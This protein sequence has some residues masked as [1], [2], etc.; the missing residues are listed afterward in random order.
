ME[1]LSHLS[2][3]DSNWQLYQQ[4]ELLPEHLSSPHKTSIGFPL[5]LNWFWRRLIGLLVAELVA[6][7]RVS[8]YLDRC[9]ALNPSDSRSRHTN[10][11][12]QLWILMD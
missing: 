2:P 7:E 11:W 3:K 8:E 10:S 6:E 4:L 5:G 9:W 1:F 12:K